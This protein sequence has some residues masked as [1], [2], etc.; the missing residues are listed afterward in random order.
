MKR[1]GIEEYQQ[2][3]EISPTVEMEKHMHCHNTGV[4]TTE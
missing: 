4:S 2:Q 1:S 3:E